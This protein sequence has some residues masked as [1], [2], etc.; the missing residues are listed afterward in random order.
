MRK[1][2]YLLLGAGPTGL[3]AAHRLK[4]LGE[5]NFL[6]VDRENMAGGLSSSYID[7]KGFTWDL[8]GH[9]QFSHYKYFDNLMQA[10]LG[11]DGWFHH[12]RESWVWIFDRF[13]PYPFQNNIK[14]LPKDIMWNCLQGIMEINKNPKNENPSNFE[15]WIYRTLGRGLAEVFMMPYNY[16]VWAYH[17]KELSSKWV[18]ERVAITDLKRVIENILFDKEDVSWGPNNTFQFPKNGGTGRIWLELGKRIRSEHF[19]YENEILEINPIKKIVK[20]SK[21]TIEYEELLNTI[22]INEMCK[23]LTSANEEILAKSSRLKF[24]STHVIGIGLK[25]N[26]KEMLKSKCWMYFPE[27]NCPFYRVTVF[28]NYSPNNVPDINSQW[29]LMAEISESQDKIVDNDLIIEDTKN[30][31]INTKLISKRT[32]EMIENQMEE[33]KEMKLLITY[34]LN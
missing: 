21:E 28:S 23:L 7:T 11:N 18:G 3:G 5:N 30:G 13:V 8:G 1:T 14:F 32:L 4:E 15:D 12:Q 33:E 20:T 22:P 6:V 17:P 26:P 2:K 10:L 25:G 27:S 19:L 29:S 16:K 9:V 31:L 24:S 34:Y